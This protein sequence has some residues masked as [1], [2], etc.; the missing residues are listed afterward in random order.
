[1]NPHS[2][3]PM[4]VLVTC[5]WFV[6][7]TG[8]GAE[9]VALEVSN[10]MA[11]AGHRVTILAT[12]PPG[13]APFPVH[14]GVELITVPAYPLSG[15]LRAQASFAPRLLTMTGRLLSTYSPDVVLSHSLQFQSTLVAAIAAQRRRLPFVVT[16][17]IADLRSIRGPLGM[18]VRIHEQ[19]I[20]R[21]ILRVAT[22]AIAVSEPVA[23]HVRS[24]A[25]RLPID[26]VPNGVDT[27]RF[28]P[29]DRPRAQR[30]RVGVL[31]RLVANKGADVAIRALAEA[32]RLGVD[33]E[34]TLAGDGPERT[35]LGRLVNL[36]G[37]HDRVRFEGHRSDP[38]HWLRAV[39]VLVRPSRTEGMPLAVLEAMAMGV[40]VIASDVPGNAALLGDG[41]TGLL[42]PVGDH[43]ALALALRRLATDPTLRDTMRLRGMEVGSAL[44]WDRTCEGTLSVL[45]RAVGNPAATRPRRM[46]AIG[47]QVP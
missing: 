23:M 14:P 4:H 31:G 25:T 33:A 6:P 36:L 16:A 40:P 46:S 9:R 38:E 3:D 44:S 10:R 47:V 8:G 29:A 13:L 17:H 30:L 26:L 34:L 43:R 42:V 19:T 41:A 18:A 7:G 32:Q 22:R 45:R 20:G 2:A 28:R 5:D 12:A 11:A 35:D 21:M 27:E 15:L 24:L 37:L 39:D 1:M